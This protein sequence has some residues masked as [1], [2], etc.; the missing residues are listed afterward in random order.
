M[1]D[2]IS[3]ALFKE[4][5]SKFLL[6][7]ALCITSFHALAQRHKHKSDE[8]T[9]PPAPT[10]APAPPR[11]FVIKPGAGYHG[12]PKGDSVYIRMY[13]NG[14][15][16][17]DYR[18][19]I[20][21][22]QHLLAIYPDSIKYKDTLALLYSQTSNYL[23][24]IIMGQEVL[25]Q[26]PNNYAVMGAVAASDQRVGRYE[27]SL[28]L[29][30]TLYDKSPNLYALYQIASLDYGLQKLGEAQGTLDRLILNPKSI[31][32]KV[33]VTVQNQ[34]Q[35]V[36]YRA[37][38]YNLMGVIYQELKNSDQAKENFKK[39]LEVQPDF[40][41]AQ[42]N[43]NFLNKNTPKPEKAPVKKAPAPKTK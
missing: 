3:L 27:E 38:A 30:K 1:R 11:D 42:Q 35:D 10:E 9:P 25:L 34:T 26:Q 14:L 32:E 5:M 43:L 33:P 41:L 22:M 24:C 4:N 8:D 2:F 28:Q 40:S 23:Q 19:S 18:L 16:Y 15:H 31:Q 17:G 13:L 29:Y 39:A 12:L 37:A 7:A 20:E 21:A 36:L 6:V